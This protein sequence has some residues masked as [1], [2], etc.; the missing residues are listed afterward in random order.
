MKRNNED[1]ILIKHIGAHWPLDINTQQ[2][3]NRKF[4][5]EWFG[6]NQWLLKITNV[7]M[8]R[9]RFFSSSRSLESTINQQN[10]GL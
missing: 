2:D 10:A 6:R 9:P 8:I 5:N 4:N 3:G 7:I 1:K